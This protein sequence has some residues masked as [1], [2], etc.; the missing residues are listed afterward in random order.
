MGR[1][2]ARQTLWPKTQ[3]SKARQ[4]MGARERQAVQHQGLQSRS[5]ARPAAGSGR[6]WDAIKVEACTL[7]KPL[8][9]SCCTW[10]LV[11]V[12]GREVPVL[13]RDLHRLPYPRVPLHRRA[14]TPGNFTNG[15]VVFE[16]PKNAH[17]RRR[18]RGQ[19][20]DSPLA[21]RLADLRHAVLVDPAGV[22][23]T[24]A[25]RVTD[26]SQPGHRPRATARGTRPALRCRRGGP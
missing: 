1:P 19:R 11:D 16:V 17:R 26:V 21:L 9:V 22:P 4:E 24:D 12:K 8:I 7:T 13:E 15:W 3:V 20:S 6:R 14:V 5:A 25:D 18:L 10:T 23:L 2:V